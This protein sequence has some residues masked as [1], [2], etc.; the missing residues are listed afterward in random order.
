[1]MVLNLNVKRAQAYAGIPS[2]KYFTIGW[3]TVGIK[4]E[5][6]TNFNGSASSQEGLFKEVSITKDGQNNRKYFCNK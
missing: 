4:L 6:G 1:M 2:K 5:S 3:R